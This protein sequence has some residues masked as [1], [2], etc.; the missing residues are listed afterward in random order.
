MENLRSLLHDDG[1]HFE[2]MTERDVLH[3]H[4]PNIAES[5]VIVKSYITK[6]E[7]K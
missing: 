4:H 7:D 5:V 3:V 1:V 6:L 2:Q